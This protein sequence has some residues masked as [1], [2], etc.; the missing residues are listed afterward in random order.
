MMDIDLYGKIDVTWGRDDLTNLAFVEDLHKDKTLNDT[1]VSAGHSIDM[2]SIGLLQEH[3]IIPD[4][5]LEVKDQFNLCKTTATIH[6]IKPGHYLP[7]HRDLYKIYKNINSITD[8]DIYRIIVFLE[9]W[10]SGH[11]LDIDGRIFNSWQAGDYVGWMNDTPHAAYNLGI[12]DRFTL[13]ITGII[14]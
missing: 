6:R 3:M 10:Q 4:W 14:C 11:M 2:M 8:E 7:I 12:T 13:Q 1:Y 9:D 5:A